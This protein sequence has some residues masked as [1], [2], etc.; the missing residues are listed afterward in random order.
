MEPDSSQAD[1][2]IGCVRQGLGCIIAMIA[3]GIIAILV[4]V[5][6]GVLFGPINSPGTP[7]VPASAYIEPS[8]LDN[9]VPND[10]IL[11][12]GK[13]GET[14]HKFHLMPRQG[15]ASIPT[16][17]PVKAKVVALDREQRTPIHAVI[18][19]GPNSGMDV[20]VTLEEMK[21]LH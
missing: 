9:V 5:M 10:V 18:L 8:P 2:P 3:L 21:Q 15:R 11:L 6:I 7:Q 13:L 14:S 4:L 17:V 12:V 1:E 20:D 19:S 16:T